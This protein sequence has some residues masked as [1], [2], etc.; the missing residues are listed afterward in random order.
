MANNSEV[1][2]SALTLHNATD[3]LGVLL[4][5][6]LGNIPKFVERA[7]DL[8]LRDGSLHCRNESPVAL[9]VGLCDGRTVELQTTRARSKIRA[10]CANLAVRSQTQEGVYNVYGGSGVI[11]A[12]GEPAEKVAA[13]W[14]N[15]TDC[16]EFFLTRFAADNH[17][18]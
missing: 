11:E 16:Q 4:D 9:V 14:T 6:R 1:A 17:S 5:D 8:A 18:A 15:T 12:N 7:I 13:R 10:A 2:A 3:S